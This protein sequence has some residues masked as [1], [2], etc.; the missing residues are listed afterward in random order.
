MVEWINRKCCEYHN[1]ALL[2]DQ[3][4]DTLGICPW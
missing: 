1:L 3:L 4:L 2:I